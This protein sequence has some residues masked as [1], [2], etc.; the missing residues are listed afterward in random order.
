MAEAIFRNLTQDINNRK[1]LYD[2]LMKG[3]DIEK[4]PEK[5]NKTK[6]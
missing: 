4:Y 2:K 6:N 3:I 5:K 1:E